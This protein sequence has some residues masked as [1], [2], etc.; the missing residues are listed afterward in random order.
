MF[1]YSD[2]EIKEILREAIVVV[3]TREQ[4]CSHIVAYFQEKKIQ[5]VCEKLDFGDYTLKVQLPHL[6]RPIYLQDKIVIERKANLNELSGNFTQG[7]ER[8]E[9][10]FLRGSGVIHLLIENASYQDILLH[11]YNTKYIPKSFI[12]TLKAFE[13]RYDL[14]VTFL[15]DS[16][17]SGDFIYKTLI[18]T[19]RELLIKGE[20]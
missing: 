4:K 10:E 2:A 1:R 11:N 3:D 19:L 12:A 16:A 9:K 18:Y 17:Y 14:K 13:A 20:I 5:Y 6:M 15:K 7:R 8:I